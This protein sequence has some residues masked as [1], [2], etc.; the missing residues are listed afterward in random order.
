VSSMM[1]SKLTAE[2]HAL[3][4]EVLVAQT[5]SLGRLEIPVVEE[6]LGRH[7]PDTLLDV[8]CGE[9]SFLLRLAQR[10]PGTRFVGIDHSERAIADADERRRRE[11]LPNVAFQAAFFDPSF[12]GTGY[13]AV[14]TR[15]TLQHASHP[16]PFVDAAFARLKPGG[17]FVALESLDAYTDCH[18]AVPLWERFRSSLAAVHRHV[19]SDQNIGKSLGVLLKR[20]GFGDIQVRI[21][22]CSPS[23]VGVERFRAVVAASARLANTF[24]PDLF[25]AGLRLDLEAWLGNREL[26]EELDPYL[27]SAVA[28]G[29]KP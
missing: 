6:V 1:E 13:G 15:Y 12:E 27:C 8:G 14:I 24:F 4:A 16:Q 5:E 17:V 29:T 9:G 2:Q 21:L 28:N 26:L 10:L 22:L 20:A 18:Q 25:D 3:L 7:R 11:G 23:T 19:G